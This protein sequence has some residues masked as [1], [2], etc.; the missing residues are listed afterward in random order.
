MRGP[1]I[2]KHTTRCAART[3]KHE[4]MSPYQHTHALYPTHLPT[5]LQ[6]C[7]TWA[8]NCIQQL[9]HRTGV[10]ACRGAA[11]QRALRKLAQHTPFKHTST[12][13]HKHTNGTATQQRRQR[14]QRL[15]HAS[16][17][18]TIP[19]GRALPALPVP[20]Q[21]TMT[22]CQ[23]MACLHAVLPQA[24]AH[25]V[26]LSLIRPGCC[27]LLLGDTRLLP[28]LCWPCMPVAL[29][30][31]TVTGNN[32]SLSPAPMDFTTTALMSGWDEVFPKSCICRSLKRRLVCTVTATW[33]R[34]QQ[35]L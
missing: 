31:C 9:Q 35:V 15:L 34:Q 16:T 22:P 30:A 12:T 4:S 14:R 33:R 11:A 20:A 28:F 29:V 32:G 2:H 27:W 17:S 7:G 25:T 19:T 6:C 8:R 26:L 1:S 24:L 5:C 10:A 21:P 23:G 3:Q 18:H 13:Q